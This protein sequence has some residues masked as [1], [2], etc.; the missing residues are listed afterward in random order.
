MESS[1][2][3]S[4]LRWRIDRTA[5]FNLM[6]ESLRRAI[7]SEENKVYLRP[8]TAQG[9]FVNFRT[10]STARVSSCR[11]AS[12]RSAKRSATRSIRATTRSVAANSSR[13]RSSSSA[14]P[15]ESMKWY[16][17]WRDVRKAWYTQLGI[18]S[19]QL[20]PREQGKEELAHLLDRHHRHRIPLPV[21]RGTPG[22]GRRRPSR[23]LRPDAAR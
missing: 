2:S 21:Q 23:R 7:Q 12:P 15:R 14:I 22:V 19:D 1:M 8:E 13:W 6:F 10:C 9:I 20:R 3:C 4:R 18:K 5:Q 11:S 16:Q 17:Y